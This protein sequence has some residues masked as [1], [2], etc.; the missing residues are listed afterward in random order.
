MGKKNLMNKAKEVNISEIPEGMCI[1]DFPE[2]TIF[3]LDE[4]E[5]EEEKQFWNKDE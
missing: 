3:V 4:D 5:A 1:D 2:D